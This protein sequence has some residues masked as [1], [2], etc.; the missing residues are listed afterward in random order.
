MKE[1]IGVVLADADENFRAM[2][3]EALE[4]SGDFTIC[5]CVGDG[6]SAL[7]AVRK[8]KAALLVTELTLPQLDGLSLLD[9]LAEENH[10]ARTIVLSVQVQNQAVE[11]ALYKGAY[12][13][14]AKP[15]DI[16]SLMARMHEAVN[17]WERPLP[18]APAEAEWEILSAL[19]AIGMPPSDEGTALACNM[20]LLTVRDPNLLRRPMKRNL[21]SRVLRDER[22]NTDN[23]ERALRSAIEAA[24]K[25]GDPELQRKIFG[26][27]IKREIGRPTNADFITVMTHYVRAS[28]HY[29]RQHGVNSTLPIGRK[30]IG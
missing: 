12:Y 21:Y 6:L 10:T 3:G 4:T 14:M 28:L 7:E 5:A 25:E 19:Y 18:E 29:Q 2:L 23:V 30:V 24:W 15:C 8:T 20:L 17:G 11:S 13:F 27:T 9:R 1:K 26:A 16:S 22:D